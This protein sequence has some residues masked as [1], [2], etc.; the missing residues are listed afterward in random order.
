MALIINT[1][2]DFIEAMRKNPEFL[3]AARRELLTRELLDLPQ[4]FAEYKEETN[5]RFD[6]VDAR[7]DG[8]DARFDGVDARFDGVDSD[9]GSL[10][11]ISLGANLEKAGLANMVADFGLR[12]TRIVRLAEHNRA[13]EEFN[14]AVWDAL[15]SGII[16]E[17]ERKRLTVTDMIARARMG[18]NTDIHAYIVAE[19]SYSLEARDIAKVRSSA[20][21]LQK[22]FPEATVFP[23][24]YAVNVSDD[25]RDEAAKRN[26]TVYLDE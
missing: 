22:V 9:L 16:S 15:H 8:V 12:R 13:S 6:A 17:D 23:C 24:L 19:A 20:D 5:A 18:R 21:A 3:A 11:G 14:E 25:L 1:T 4:R 10:K 2:D 26:I 7:F